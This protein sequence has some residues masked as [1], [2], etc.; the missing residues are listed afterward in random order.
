MNWWVSWTLPNLK[1]S[2]TIHTILK[3]LK[4]LTHPVIYKRGRRHLLRALNGRLIY[5]ENGAKKRRCRQTRD[6]RRRSRWSTPTRFRRQGYWMMSRHPT[7]N[8][9]FQTENRISSSAPFTHL[10]IKGNAWE[11]QIKIILSPAIMYPRREWELE[12]Y[13]LKDKAWRCC[14]NKEERKRD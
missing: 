10:H 3:Q 13:D 5:A 8:R 12:T 11:N 2:E 14:N 1:I 4:L 7:F 9:G 6:D